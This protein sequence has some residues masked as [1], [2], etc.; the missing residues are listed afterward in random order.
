MQPVADTADP[1][2]LFEDDLAWAREGLA[3]VGLDGLG[4]HVEWLDDVR[5]F[6]LRPPPDLGLR[7][8]YLPPELTRGD[9]LRLTVDRQR[10][11]TAHARARDTGG[12]GR[13]GGVWWRPPPG[14][15]GLGDRGLEGS[16]RPGAPGGG[17]GGPPPRGGTPGVSQPAWSNARPHPVIVGWS[18]VVR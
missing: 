2:S 12:G 6:R 4:G 7:Y 3:Q 18:A 13:G 9:E 14:R 11:M 17:G 16:R 1:P 15:G 5:G 8:E 10:V